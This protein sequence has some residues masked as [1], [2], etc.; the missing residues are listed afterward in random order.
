M[1]CT[2]A[3]LEK[4][5]VV[6]LLAKAVRAGL[7]RKEAGNSRP[8][9]VCELKRPAAAAGARNALEPGHLGS[10]NWKIHSASLQLALALRMKKTPSTVVT[11]PWIIPRN[12]LDLL[13]ISSGAELVKG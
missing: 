4:L 2:V 3:E 5:A 8:A 9:I 13:K 10:A 1:A 6:R 12:K 7:D 11:N